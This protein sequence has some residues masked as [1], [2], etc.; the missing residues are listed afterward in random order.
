LN[1]P[2]LRRVLLPGQVAFTTPYWVIVTAVAL[3]GMVMVGMIGSPSVVTIVPW[4]FS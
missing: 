3:A 1:L 2:Q 4:L